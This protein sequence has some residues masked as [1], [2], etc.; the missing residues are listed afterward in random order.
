MDHIPTSGGASFELNLTHIAEEAFERCGLEL[1]SGYDLRTAR[2]SMNI[3]LI[4][5]A[6]RGINLW[7]VTQGFIPL[8]EGVT[9]YV[10]PDSIVDILD[11]VISVPTSGR[12][13]DYPMNRVSLN[14]YIG[15]PNKS[16][17]G[18]PTQFWVDRQAFVKRTTPCELTGV[19]NPTDTSIF[20]SNVESLPPEGWIVVGE[21]LIRYS[22]IAS[23][24]VQ[25]CERQGSHTHAVGA[26]V[27]QINPSTMNVWPAPSQDM[28]GNQISYWYLRRMDDAG[29]GGVNAQEVPY[30][31]L[32]A[33]IAGL[34]YYLSQK[35]TGVPADRMMYLKQEY[36][37]QWALAATEDRDKSTIRIV[38]MS[39]DRKSVV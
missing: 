10:I 9:K 24:G 8:K 22:G 31:F 29:I 1:S 12:K 3:M 35:L 7:T 13:Y 27:Y 33:M 14:T 6:N 32:P 28:E 16:A 17:L 37:E 5:W 20:M 38:P 2:R 36:E 11:C 15:I 26:S 4:E 25:N 30:R 39:I 19:V 23:G 18:R 34:A 21:E